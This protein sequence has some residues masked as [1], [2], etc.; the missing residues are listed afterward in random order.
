MLNLRWRES[1]AGSGEPQL[2][3]TQQQ[4]AK[5]MRGVQEERY[6]IAKAAQLFQVDP[7]TVSRLMAGQ[8]PH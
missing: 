7:A 6:G 5:L 1:K 3:L 2:K 8:V 4:Q